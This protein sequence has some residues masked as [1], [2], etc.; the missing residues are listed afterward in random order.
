MTASIGKGAGNRLFLGLDR[1]WG[2]DRMERGL[3][4]KK[5]TLEDEAEP[6]QGMMKGG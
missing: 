3:K 6:V 5:I 2:R 4:R 1:R